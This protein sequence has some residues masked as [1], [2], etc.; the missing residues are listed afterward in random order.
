MGGIVIVVLVGV[1][2]FLGLMWYEERLKNNYVV[3]NAWDKWRESKWE[4]SYLTHTHTYRGTHTL[5]YRERHTDTVK[6]RL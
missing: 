6:E 4:N 2:V 1:L 5:I 3:H